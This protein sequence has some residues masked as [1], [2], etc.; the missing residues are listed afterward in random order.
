MGFFIL[1]F[2]T[3]KIFRKKKLKILQKSRGRNHPTKNPPKLAG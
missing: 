1:N 2:S 3:N